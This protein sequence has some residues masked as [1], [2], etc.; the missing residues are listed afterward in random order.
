[1]LLTGATGFIG[2]RL[3]DRLEGEGLGLRAL[4]RDRSR[5]RGP[6]TDGGFEVVE[7]DLAD[8]DSLREALKKVDVAFYLVHSMEPGPSGFAERDREAAENY[9]GCAGEAGVRR[10]IYLGGVTPEGEHSE[11]IESRL[12][13]ERILSESTPE[14]VGLRAS[15]IVGSGSASFRTLAQIVE[16]APALP[17]P[18]WRDRRTQPVAVDDV[19]E[20]LVR[21]RDA[22]PGVY[23]I[24]GCDTL[25]FAEMTETLADLLGKEHRALNLPVRRLPFEGAAASLVT[26]SDREL[27]APLMEGLHDDLLVDENALRS[28]FGVEP[29]PFREAARTALE[30]MR[31]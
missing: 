23:E 27:V 31:S 25:S 8:R 22:E 9:A 1:M 28:V 2:G 18:E 5:L 17:L 20:C 24:A 6:R 19:V 10:T 26:D 11:H 4:V 3:L 16:R 29:T 7:A 14:F 21:A 13:V 30:G 15:M 12:E